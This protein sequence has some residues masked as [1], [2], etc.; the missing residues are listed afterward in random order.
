MH[1]Y[2]I[3]SKGNFKNVS[4]VVPRAHHKGLRANRFPKLLQNVHSMWESIF[5]SPIH[6]C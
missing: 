5:S 1:K 2:I 4:V 3:N 6:F